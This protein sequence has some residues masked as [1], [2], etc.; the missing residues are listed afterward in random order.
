MPDPA[1]TTQRL[2][3]LRKLTRAVA[4]FLRGQLK[5]YLATLGPL[6]RPRAVLGDHIQSSVKEPVKGSDAAFKELQA[7]YNSLAA[8]K[9]FHFNRELQSPIEVLSSVLEI[10][11][12]EYTHIAKTD[13]V[14]KTV[15]VT[16][17]LKWVLSYGGFG[18]KRLK[19]QL[20]LRSQATTTTE[21]EQLVVHHLLLHI[22]TTKQTSVTKVLEALHFPISSGRLP[23]CGELPITFIA[24]ALPT[25]RPPDEVIIESTEI[26][27]MDAFEEVIDLDGIAKLRDPVV[28]RVREIAKSCGEEIGDRPA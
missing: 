19:D 26:S 3:A 4:D 27:G 7:L 24:A 15:T 22:V 18:P 9:P 16:T 20:A 5:E 10:T 21:L 14:S 6:L 8:A 11:P 1:F 23:G 28:E 13:S 12:V 17:P 2:L 25:V